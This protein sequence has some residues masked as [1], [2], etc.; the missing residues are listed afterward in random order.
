MPTTIVAACP[1]H[2]LAM[3]VQDLFINSYFRVYTNED[4]AGVEIAAAKM[5]IRD[6]PLVAGIF[7]RLRHYRPHLSL[8]YD[9][10][11]RHWY[12]WNHCCNPARNRPAGSLFTQAF[13]YSDHP[14]RRF[15]RRR[16]SAILFHRRNL[17]LCGRSL[18]KMC[19]RDRR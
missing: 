14:G 3:Q 10:V 19:I 13:I 6:R 1:D 15:Q 12:G 18:I 7:R 2:N 8:R 17:R 5:C 11:Q 4:M 16:S 9:R